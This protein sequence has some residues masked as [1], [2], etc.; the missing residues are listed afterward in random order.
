MPDCCKLQ[1]VVFNRICCD[2]VHITV[3]SS[4]FPLICCGIDMFLMFAL[5]GKDAVGEDVCV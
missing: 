2:L 5:F 3:S 1:V 4:S